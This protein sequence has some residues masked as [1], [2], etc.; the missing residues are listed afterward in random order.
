MCLQKKFRDCHPRRKCVHCD[1]DIDKVMCFNIIPKLLVFSV[2]DASVRV[3]KKISFR[4][5]DSMIVFSLKGIVYFGD[6]H[7]TARV[8]VGGSVWFH[9]GMS[10]GRDCTYEKR[11]NEFTDVE[12]STCNG[13]TL[14][15]VFYAQR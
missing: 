4:D 5:G 15:L 6:F 13:K 9:D 10:T 1:G 8:C 12:L 3:S 11:L 7:Y 2:F 14:S